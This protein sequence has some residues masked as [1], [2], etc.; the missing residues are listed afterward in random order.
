LLDKM[1]FLEIKG[2]GW[3]CPTSGCRLLEEVFA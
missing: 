1:P 3:L 2:S